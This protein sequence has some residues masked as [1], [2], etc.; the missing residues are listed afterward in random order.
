M[1]FGTFEWD[2]M[3][4]NEPYK[5]ISFGGKKKVKKTTKEGTSKMPERSNDGDVESKNVGP[6]LPPDWVKTTQTGSQSY[7]ETVHGI[8]CQ[9]KET[10]VGGGFNLKNNI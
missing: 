10:I 9:M 1:K 5:R 2:L 6:K 7:D 3:Q 4:K 8:N